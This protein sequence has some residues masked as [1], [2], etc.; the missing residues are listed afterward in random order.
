MQTEPE[1]LSE[2]GR[3]LLQ[4]PAEELLFSA[5]AAWEI[6]IKF[7]LGKLRL[8]A[9]PAAFVARA[10]SEDRLATLPI[11]HDHALRAGELPPHHRDPFDRLLIAQAQLESLTVL[12][13]DRQFARYDVAVLWV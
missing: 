12:T 11:S 9:P 8:P 7:A 5:A 1:R 10:L 4:D 13:A 6:A 3:R 2:A